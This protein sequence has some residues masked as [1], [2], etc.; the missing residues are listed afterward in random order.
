MAKLSRKKGTT[1]QIFHIFIQDSSSTTGAG[2][3]GLAYN[4]ANLACRYINAGGTLSGAITLQDI[5][6]LGTYEAPTANTNMRFKE[7]SSASPSQ[8]I[9]EI[10]VH[11][12]WMN[13][14]GGSLV[15][16]LAGVTN[17][18]QLRLEIDLGTDAIISVNNDKTG[19]SISGTKTTLDALN[20]ITAA[21]ILATVLTESY[22]ADGAT[23][24]L[25]QL[26]YM[27]WSA[28]GDFSISGTT[29]TCKKLDGT[30]TA[31]TFTLD[32]G[33]NPTSRTRAT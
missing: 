11:N 8:G 5:T 6:T 3:T 2:L 1:S 15:I 24:T 31:M 22:A 27:L 16:M 7:V 30:T 21:N 20:D 32:D 10:H 26:L 13:L 14:T 23:P 9:Y 17:M 18:A 19:Y 25:T 12:D 29:I 4:S 33:T 28:I